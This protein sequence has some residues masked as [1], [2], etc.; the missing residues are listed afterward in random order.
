MD[1]VVSAVRELR[2]TL[3]DSQQAFAGRLGLSV[4]AVANYESNRRPGA[5]V[6][7]GLAT[8]AQQH[9]LSKL[10]SVF[11]TAYAQRMKGR[12]EPTTPEETAWVRA[13]LALLRNRELV[14]DWATLA[15]GFVA[16]LEHLATAA[17]RDRSVKTD[18]RELEE[19]LLEL[20]YEL[21]E[22][23]ERELDRRARERSAQTSESFGK[24]YAG[25][26]ADD[27]KLY[28]RYQQERADAARGTLFEST[29]AVSGTR[30]QRE[31]RSKAGKE[32]KS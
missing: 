9:K 15:N 18:A 4:R 20:R 2:K 29:L 17:Q 6:L 11:S 8:L 13:T 26:L 5:S 32:K 25:V 14:P 3:G 10:E 12:I 30:Q 24:A 7:L 28:E 31:K 23:A 21:N 27:P 16:A 22:T 19:S 1:D